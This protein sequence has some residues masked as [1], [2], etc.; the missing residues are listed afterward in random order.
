MDY[1]DL[2]LIRRFRE[3]HVK[4]VD[5]G[6]YAAYPTWDIKRNVETGIVDMEWVCFHKLPP[7]NV[8]RWISLVIE[9][10]GMGILFQ[11]FMNFLEYPVY[12]RWINLKY[13]NLSLKDHPKKPFLSDYDR[14]M[15]ATNIYAL[16]KGLVGGFPTF[17]D[18]RGS[19]KMFCET[20]TLNS[21]I[22][23]GYEMPIEMLNDSVY[24]IPGGINPEIGVG[25][26]ASF[27]T[28]HKY[29][30]SMG[31]LSAFPTYIRP[32]PGVMGIVLVYQ[33]AAEILT[34]SYKYGKNGWEVII[35]A[36][37]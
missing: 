25:V 11:K 24:P 15:K 7:K 1:D 20:I 36:V 31:Y 21:D 35:P 23:I 32:S 5:L 26:I 14:R 8:R 22:S 17:L 16:K 33:G 29:A 10:L 19:N 6:Y 37:K 27:E 34:V 18:K 2:D 3:V 4:G 13:L 28:A 12:K 30:K 9:A